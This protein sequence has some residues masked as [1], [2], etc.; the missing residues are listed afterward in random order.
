MDTLGMSWL[1]TDRDSDV[2]T[3]EGWAGLEGCVHRWYVTCGARRI[4]FAPWLTGRNVGVS[5]GSG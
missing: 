1:I 4:L 2:S 3:L 5:P